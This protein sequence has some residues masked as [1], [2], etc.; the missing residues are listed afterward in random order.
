MKETLPLHATWQV[1]HA[2]PNLGPTQA[3]S[4]SKVEERWVPATVPG[5][6]HLDYERAGLIGDPFYGLNQLPSFI[7]P[8]WASTEVFLIGSPS[9]LL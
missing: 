1:M 6:V 7:S 4:A 2:E 3:C 8:L 5:D 9:P